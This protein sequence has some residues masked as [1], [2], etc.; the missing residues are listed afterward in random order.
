MANAVVFV[1]C[2]RLVKITLL[3]CLCINKAKMVIIYH[4][5]LFCSWKYISA[6]DVNSILCSCEC[7]INFGTILG[8]NLMQNLGPKEK[9]IS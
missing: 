8:Y 1:L 9:K 2:A 4:L 7:Q 6:F 3:L 5:G